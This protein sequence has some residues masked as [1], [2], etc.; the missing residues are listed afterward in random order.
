MISAEDTRTARPTCARCERPMVTC[1]CEHLPS[2]PTR[3]HVL[4][5]Q[6]PREEKMAIGTARMAHLALPNSSLRVGLELGDDPVLRAAIE[7]ERPTYVLFPG[8]GSIDVAELPR[9]R[10]INLVVVDGTWSQAKTLLRINPVLGRLPRVGFS[11]MRPSQYQIRR[12][13]DPMFVS[14]IEALAEVLGQ[15]EEREGGFD[16]LLDPF[17]AMVARQ[18]RFATEVKASRHARNHPMPRPARKKPIG[19]R[20]KEAWPRLVCVQGDANGW[21]RLDVD[22]QPSETV[23]WTAYRPDSG[24]AFEAIIA[25]RRALG[26]ATAQ[27]LQISAER[28]MAGLSLAA[29]HEAWQGFLRPDDVLVYWGRYYRDLAERDGLVLPRKTID[30]RHEA[31]TLEGGRVGTVEDYLATFPTKARAVGVEGRA[32]GRLAALVGVTDA[33]RES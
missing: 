28:L 32:G 10:A 21:P 18:A 9:D 20:L 31:A 6:H 29:W 16:T 19:R 24:E 13:P 15:L 5:L 7:G 4:L 1:Y 27:H 3:T 11:P 17:R 2:L 14:T 12:Q 30:M 22:R 25:P 26:P 33:L 23:H 8:P